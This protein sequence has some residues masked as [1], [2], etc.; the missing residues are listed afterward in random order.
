MKTSA[1]LRP[2]E[3]PKL[4][5]SSTE[6][7]ELGPTEGRRTRLHL[8]AEDPVMLSLGSQIT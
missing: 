8:I 6:A 3:M 5:I 4:G 2:C 7:F 1:A